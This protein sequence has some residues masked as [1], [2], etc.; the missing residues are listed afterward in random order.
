MFLSPPTT[1][2]FNT[3]GQFEPAFQRQRIIHAKLFIPPPVISVRRKALLTADMQRGHQMPGGLHL[4]A[5]A[6]V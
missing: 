5:C 6:S 2:L 1:S 3:P 4:Q